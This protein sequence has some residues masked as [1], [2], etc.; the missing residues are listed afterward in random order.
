M[1]MLDVPQGYMLYQFLLHFGD[2]P[3]K[4]FRIMMDG[5]ERYMQRNKLVKEIHYLKRAMEAGDPALARPVND[6][7]SLNWLCKECPYLTDC[8]KIQDATAAS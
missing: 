4:A 8:K 3:F 5:Q 7:A 1:A 2:K 6:D